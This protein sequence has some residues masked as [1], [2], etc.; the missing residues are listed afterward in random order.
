MTGI[1]LA[2]ACVEDAP[3]VAAF[4]TLAWQQTY[5]GVIDDALLDVPADDRVER[6]AERIGSG[7]RSVT[8][9][10]KG[11]SVVGVASTSVD[12]PPRAG[13]PA[14]ELNTLYLRRDAQGIGLGSRLLQ[15][16]IGDDAAHLLAFEFNASAHAFYRR[17]SFT[18]EGAVL[19]DPGTGLRERRWVRRGIVG[20]ADGGTRGVTG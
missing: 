19:L 18:P 3:A 13:L 6:W 16:A 14:L 17:R 20:G 9:A 12:D 2:R 7:S 4:Q 1:T 11:R 15:A 5:R 10:W 8:I